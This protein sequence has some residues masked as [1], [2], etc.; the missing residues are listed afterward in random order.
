MHKKQQSK[1]QIQRRDMKTFAV[2]A[3][4]L[5]AGVAFTKAEYG[6]IE[7]FPADT[8]GGQLSELQEEDFNEEADDNDD[9]D[10]AN[11]YE[12]KFEDDDAELVGVFVMPAATCYTTAPVYRIISN[13]G[14]P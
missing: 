7:E 11:S 13:I 9:A 4:I 12:E 8:D 1:L 5:L 10:I 2:L 3:L 6:D 14:A